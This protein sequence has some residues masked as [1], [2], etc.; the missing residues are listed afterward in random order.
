M[1][2][3][4]VQVAPDSTGGKIE[5]SDLLRGDNTLVKRQRV[6]VSD[7]DN[8]LQLLNKNLELILREIRSMRLDILNAM[9]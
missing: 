2:D 9:H 5:T 7:D 8:A 1:T 4:Y 6:T 3:G